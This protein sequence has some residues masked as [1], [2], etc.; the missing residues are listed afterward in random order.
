MTGVSKI[1]A[2]ILL[3]AGVVLAGF[4]YYLSQ[5]PAPVPAP[6][7]PSAVADAPVQPAVPAA[8]HPVVLASSNIV[9]GTRLEKDM[10][11]VQQWPIALTQG[12]VKVEDV[13]GEVARLDIAVGEPV[14][15]QLLAQGLSRQ[16]RPGERA[17]AI[18]VDEVVGAGNRVAPGDMV[19]VFFAL[20]KNDEVQ[21]SQVRLLQSRIRVLAYGTQSV[22]GPPPADDKAS[23][24]RASAVTA[25]SAVL[26]VPV[27]DV[28]ELLLATKAGQLQL[29]LRSPEDEVI[30][31]RDLFVQRKSVVPALATLS[32]E[33]RESLNDGPNRAYAG[34]SLA[35]LDAPAPQV[36]KKALASGSGGGRTIEVLRGDSAQRVRY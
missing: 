17:I 16:L 30:P 33:Q 21:G 14:T 26:A 19:D 13:V 25:R 20:K 34:D 15:T 8:S 29:A 9:A 4:S 3:L 35:Q 1:F 18:A 5:R 27:A 24:Q 2:A 36:A 23:P 32:A 28:N 12:Y 31:D 11:K 10:L 7:P 6:A 22:D